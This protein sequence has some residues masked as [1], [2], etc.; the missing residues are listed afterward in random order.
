MAC[1]NVIRQCSLKQSQERIRYKLT[2]SM[3]TMFDW[4]YDVGGLR[5][6]AFSMSASLDKTAFT[7]YFFG[8][9][10]ALKS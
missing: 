1:T 2:L 8:A 5:H 7:L 3:I 9:L 4:L 10:D 6:N